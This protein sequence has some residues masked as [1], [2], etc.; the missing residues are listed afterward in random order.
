[1]RI[2]TLETIRLAEYPNLLWVQVGTDDGLTGL[3]ETFFGARAVAAYLHES[4]APQLLGGDPL[5]IESWSR[6]LRGYLGGA[7]AG[8]ESRG[9]S[10]I[11]L[12]LWDLL[13][14]AT[15][16]PLH[17][18]LGGRTRE[19]IPVYNT[20]AGPRYIRERPVQSVDNWG[21]PRGVPHPL[22]DLAAS[23]SRPGEL[24]AELLDEGITAMK[25]WPFDPI[26]EAREGNWPSA[27]QLDAALTP[28]RRIREAVGDRMDV[29]VELH[30]GWTVSGAK[31]VA[32]ALEPYAPRWLED[33][34]RPANATA[35][36]QVAAATTAPIAGGETIGWTDAFRQLLS[37]GALDVLIVDLTWCG[38]LTEARR[39]AALAASFDVAVAPHDCTG[40]VAL[41]ACTH[42][43]ASL[44][45]AIV[46]EFTRAAHR[47]WYR[48]L[49]TDLPEVHEGHIEP[50]T[51]PGLGARLV[52]GLRDRHDATVL[53]SRL[54][55]DRVD[56]RVL[57]GAEGSW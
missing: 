15:G 29:M 30:S 20:C 46:Q 31:R 42:L 33:P 16:Q 36:A 40:P 52:P 50:L 49:L 35:L 23:L 22:D 34:V 1:M 48:E 11:D 26:A 7:G 38:G 27:A 6:R 4:V 47:T 3:G 28:I 56:T 37:L 54:D 41:T 19:R 17:V 9:N 10:A 55:G 43:S 53:S 12:A 45:N 32:R 18:L 57:V 14:L 39:I 21:L 44:P 24:A 51:A 2:T 25:I 8:V 5:A 13:G